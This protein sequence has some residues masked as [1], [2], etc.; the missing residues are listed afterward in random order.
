MTGMPKLKAV[1][2]A[3]DHQKTKPI[4]KVNNALAQ[5]S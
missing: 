4:F 2:T 3:N 1:G 5:G